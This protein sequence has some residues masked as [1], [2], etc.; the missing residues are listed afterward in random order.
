VFAVAV[1]VV[2]A[3]VS[4]AVASAASRIL[5]YLLLTGPGSRLI[6]LTGDPGRLRSRF[7]LSYC[8]AVTH[9]HTHTQV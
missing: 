3:V 8:I 4:A 2:A 9:T 1:V 5:W 7:V 6:R